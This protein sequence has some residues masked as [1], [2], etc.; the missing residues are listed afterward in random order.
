MRTFVTACLCAFAWMAGPG[1]AGAPNDFAARIL[2]AH[3][4]ERT[5]LQLP[6]LAWSDTLAAAAA[7]WANRL[8]E[9]GRPEHSP[10]SVRP[11]IGENLWAGTAGA[12]TPEEMVQGWAAEKEF[13]H[14]GPFALPTD[15]HVVGHY[16]QMIWKNTT[17]VGC[18][19]A[20]MGTWDVLVCRYAPEGNLLGEKPY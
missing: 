4:D 12:F 7:E 3:N 16:T 18:A 20:K 13:Y 2:T 14:Y 15:G 1:F 10:K 11:G 17:E 9:V 5:A 8:V 19:T 6:P